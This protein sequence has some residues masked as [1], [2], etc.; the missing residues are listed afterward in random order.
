M[1]HDR[2]PRRSHASIKQSID[3]S[4]LRVT[5]ASTFVA[6]V[7]AAAAFW[8]G[9]EAHKTRVDDSRPL[10]TTAP[11]ERLAGSPF[12]RIQITEIGKSTAKNV[13]ASCKAAIESNSV[14]TKWDS[15]A[16]DS[17]TE[18][19]PYLQPSVWVKFNCPSNDSATLPQNG[20]AVE[21][22]VIQY[23]DLD[24]NQYSTPFCFSFQTPYNA[25][26]IHECGERRNLPELK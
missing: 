9:Y 25:I 24:A 5:I 11:A 14:A 17:P 12:V 2:L 22:G 20:L 7:S 23:E 4:T 16:S 18:T 10:L 6:V 8:S 3:K 26:D 15:K 19:F 21:M 1:E 13:R